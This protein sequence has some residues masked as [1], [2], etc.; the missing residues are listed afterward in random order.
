MAELSFERTWTVT[1]SV[2]TDG[3]ALFIHRWVL[4]PVPAQFADGQIHTEQL[5]IPKERP[6]FGLKRP[7]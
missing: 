4:I 6:G 3:A 7:F 2:L 5:R 1:N